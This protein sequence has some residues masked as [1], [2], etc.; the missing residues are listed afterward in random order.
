MN[1]MDARRT[2]SLQNASLAVARLMP[3][4]IRGVQ[5]DFFLKKGVTQ[6]QFLVLIAIHSYGRAGMGTL[7]RS[8]H[9]TMPTTSGIVDR[10]ARS[11][12]VR[13]SPNPRDRR[14]VIV[15]TTAKGEAFIAQFQGVI[16]RRWGEVLRT[17]EP[18]ELD[19]FHHVVTKLREQIQPRG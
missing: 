6:T 15:E 1:K 14:Q 3:N 5:L 9:V 19:A 2:R 11:G 16:R 13:R 8:L 4:I 12:Y 17:L 7:A 10:L 18:R